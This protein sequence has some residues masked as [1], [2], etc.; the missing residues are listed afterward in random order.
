MLAECYCSAALKGANARRLLAVRASHSHSKQQQQQQL[1]LNLASTPEIA[2][3]LQ[4][5]VE[6][7]T[8]EGGEEKEGRDKPTPGW[9]GG[10]GDVLSS[11]RRCISALDI[12]EG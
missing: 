6:T 11:N 2:L 7:L 9:T 4:P 8:L 5:P 12:I 10:A 1:R 3:C